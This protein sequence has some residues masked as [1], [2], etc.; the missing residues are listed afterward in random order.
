MIGYAGSQ[1]D[2]G[3][4][5]SWPMLYNALWLRLLGFDNLLPNQGALLAQQQ[6]WYARGS[7]RARL[8]GAAV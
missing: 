4:P 8:Y 3:D 6:A 7:V 2:G 5:A 1:G